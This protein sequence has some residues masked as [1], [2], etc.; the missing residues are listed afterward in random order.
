MIVLL[1]AGVIVTVLSAVV[2]SIIFRTMWRAMRELQSHGI[3][4]PIPLNLKARAI[5][6][7]WLA[8]FIVGV[9]MI[10]LSY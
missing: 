6:W 1:I 8:A 2:L 7:A 4:E 9:A 3:N 5:I 10:G